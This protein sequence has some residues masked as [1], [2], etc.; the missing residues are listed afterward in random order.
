[1]AE[2]LMDHFLLT[3][4]EA[5]SKVRWIEAVTDLEDEIEESIRYLIDD[6]GNLEETLSALIEVQ[7]RLANARL[8][9]QAAFAGVRKR[10]K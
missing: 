7:Q 3:E 2:S 5:Y 8:N 6:E 9:L 4:E 1:M 10:E